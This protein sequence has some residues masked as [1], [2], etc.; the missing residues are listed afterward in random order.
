MTALCLAAA[1]SP[2]SLV[3]VQTNSSLVDPSQVTTPSGATQLYN[4][5]VLWAGSVLIMGSQP[6][7]SDIMCSSGI[8]TDEL[9]PVE[10]MDAMFPLD[11]RTVNENG[12]G[13]NVQLYIS[14][15]QART[16]L[17]QARQ[18]LQLYASNT[19][20]IPKAWQGQLYALEGYTVLWFAELFCSGIP[21]T[22]VPLVGKPQPTA[23][24]TT[25]QLFQRAIVLFDSAI[26]A[27]AD[28]AQ[29]VNL[30]K[31]GKGRAQLGLGDF[32]DA[33]ATVQDVPTQFVYAFS[34]LPSEAYNDLSIG[35]YGVSGQEFVRTQDNEGT[36]GLTWSSDP[37]TLLITIDSISGPMLM[38]A[39][40]NVTASGTVD[41]LTFQS[42]APV[43]IADG[44]E[45]RLI[46]AE[47]ALAAGDASWLTTLN[48]LRTTCIG[49][50]ACAPVP[51]LTTTN[52]PP[53]A[54]PGTADARLDLLMKER[55]MW[56]YLTGHREGDLRRMAHVYHRDPLTL[57]PTGT[58][59]SPAFPPAYPDATTL[60]GAIYG[61]DVVFAPDPNERVNNPLYGGCVNMNP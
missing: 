55:A 35:S 8:F 34:A 12:S 44:L 58:V 14:L 49:S 20:S 13:S 52:L 56:L 15:H 50:A 60:D 38:S 57:W 26:V 32:T 7:N 11:Q 53:L 5:A 22:S 40:Y 1:C 10:G 16:R 28:S 4:A 2:S 31:V 6:C 18:A 29:F 43:R 39:K 9:T 47:A 61:S 17:Q 27:G 51:G 33:A 19:P 36:N 30:A 48:M 45:A 37:R 46:G 3:D 41:P 24:F 42:S 21:L 54:D 25:E 59:V 23:G